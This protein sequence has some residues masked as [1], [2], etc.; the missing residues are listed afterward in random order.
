[1]TYGQIAITLGE[2][3]TPRT[4]GFVMRNANADEV[5]WQRVINSRGGCSTGRILAPHDI[6]QQLLEAEGVQFNS[7]GFCRLEDY[8]WEPDWGTA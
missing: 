5:P 7:K 6:Q 1:M 4:V 8:R 3:Y 2:G